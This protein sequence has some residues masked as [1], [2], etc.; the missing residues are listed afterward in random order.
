MTDGEGERL[1]SMLEALYSQVLLTVLARV[2][3]MI[4]MIEGERRQAKT[5][6]RFDEFQEQTE[7]CFSRLMELS[8]DSN[9]D[10]AKV[11]IRSI[12]SSD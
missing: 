2:D 5:K 10:R 3:D 11:T 1:F 7:T 6:G 12:R 4:R 9:L 8:L